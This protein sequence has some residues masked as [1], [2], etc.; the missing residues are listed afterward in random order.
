MKKIFL[1]WS[2]LVMVTMLFLSC[3][4]EEDQVVFD[5]SNTKNPGLA[6]SAANVVLAEPDNAKTAVSFTLQASDYGF[7]A[8]PVYKL[9]ID[10]KGNNFKS[11]TETT[12]GNALQKSFTV[13][14]LN[15]F[16]LEKLS[17]IAGVSN[18]FEAR[19][20]SD[21]SPAVASLYSNVVSFSITPYFV[22]QEYPVVYVPGSYQ[23]WAPD[24][25]EQLASVNYD[26]I[27]EGYI[28][29]PD[30]DTEFKI[31]PMPN[32]DAD[33]G[34]DGAKAGK[35]KEKGDNIKVAEAG[36]Y[37]IKADIPGLKYSVTKTTWGVIGDATAASGGWDTDKPMTYNPVKKVWTVTLD[38]IG[39][40]EMKFR[41]NG[42]WDINYG[43][44]AKDGSAPPDGAL[45]FDAAN[46]KVANSG[47]YTITLNLG[48]PGNYSY[49]LKKN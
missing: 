7:S 44:G 29:F 3:D 11:P 43:D 32:W 22:V 14:E 24:K 26:D 41:A 6:V 8:G 46:I 25:A 4:K 27:Y 19:V 23:G 36:Y 49:A 33:W 18:D 47:N 16:A 42:G 34:D 20:K 15:K 31:T 17:A 9:Q 38:L 21:L 48:T 40:K 35:L 5:A 12:L 2:A 39:G 13:K 1:Y 10:K 37:W 45:D 28:N 30:K